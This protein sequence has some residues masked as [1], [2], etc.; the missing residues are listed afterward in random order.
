MSTGINLVV[1]ELMFVTGPNCCSD[2]LNTTY[3]D[4]KI[5]CICSEVVKFT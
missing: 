5:Q 4:I 2:L 1:H 3:K